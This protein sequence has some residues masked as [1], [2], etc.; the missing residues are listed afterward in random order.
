MSELKARLGQLGSSFGSA[1]W[2]DNQGTTI[3]SL[4]CPEDSRF[5]NEAIGTASLQVQVSCLQQ[6]PAT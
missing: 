6:L 4:N 3:C 1:E 2:V 5:R